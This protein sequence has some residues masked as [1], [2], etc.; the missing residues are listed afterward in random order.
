MKNIKLV[1]YALGFSF[2]LSACNSVETSV[3]IEKNIGYFVSNF[4][5]HVDY[6]CENK[7]QSMNE[8]GKFECP[9]FPIAFY[10]DNMKIGQISNIHEDGYVYP[11]DIIVLEDI[12]P[13]Y[14]SEN[15]ISYLNIE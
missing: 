3:D 1:C 10:M 11:Q 8:S 13:V 9:S 7:R 14:T 15:S 5:E 2:I 12:V 6:A 4:N